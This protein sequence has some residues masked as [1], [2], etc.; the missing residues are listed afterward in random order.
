MRIPSEKECY[1]LISEMNMM[2]HIVDHSV[3]VSRVAVF[4]VD[5]MDRGTIVLN[6][7]L[8]LASALLHDITKTRSFNTR[9]NHATTGAQFLYDCGYQHVGD[10]VGQHVRLNEY[11]ISR[12]PTEAEIVN[13]AD[14][15]VLH[16]QIVPLKDRMTYIL[17]K[18]GKAIENQQRIQWL[19]KKT[20]ALERRLFRYL[21]FSP[22]E[23]GKLMTDGK[24]PVIG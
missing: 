14:K 22:D 19:W 11:F 2:D 9:E 7:R 20:E 23:L 10:V 5:H 17:K 16:D 1:R 8:V 12:L 6:R 13:Y 21:P 4:L 15:R 18:Y 24:K 3:Q